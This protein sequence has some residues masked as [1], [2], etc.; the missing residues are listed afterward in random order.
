[1]K[2]QVL[3]RLV[4]VN[5]DV[6]IWSGRKKLTAEDLSLGDDV[7]PEDLVSLGSKR[8]CDP[9]SI[10]VFHRL[11]KQAERVCLT[12][13]MRFLGGY[14]VPED[15]TETVA[16]ELDALGETFAKERA[17]FVSGYGQAIEDWIALHPQW[18]AAIR[19]AVDPASVV[20]SRLGFGYQLYRIAPAESAGDLAEQV[21]GLGDTLFGEV[22]QIARELD[23]SFVG[24]DALSQRALS[25]FR[26]I[27][28]KLGC[29]TFVDY[30]VQPVLDSLEDWLARV[31]GKGPV[32]GALFNEG[33]G[34]M[35]LVSDPQRMSDHGAG[36]LALQDLIPV[37]EDPPEDEEKEKDECEWSFGG[38]LGDDEPDEKTE[39]ARRPERRP[40]RCGK[41]SPRRSSRTWAPSWM[42]SPV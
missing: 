16:A 25:T 4:A 1:M 35:L 3:D 12:G 19:K 27:R 26:R 32:T 38:P 14:A 22:A 41:S 8:V 30:R 13:G 36:I 29:L 40:T 33:F 18:E 34:L 11:K 31:P 17:I 42:R 21:E 20:E 6:R 37:H 15:R 9:N 39:I 5:L 23:K 10:K 28:E 7:P 24:K 2:M